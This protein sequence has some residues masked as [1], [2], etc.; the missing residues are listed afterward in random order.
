MFSCGI[1]GLPVAE[2]EII[3]E[4]VKGEITTGA[5]SEC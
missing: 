1:T 2:G 3:N 5:Q 4:V